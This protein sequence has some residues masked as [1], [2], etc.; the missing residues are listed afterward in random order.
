MKTISLVLVGC[1]SLKDWIKR[2]KRKQLVRREL[3]NLKLRLQFFN[4]NGKFSRSNWKA[5][6][7]SYN[8]TSAT[9]KVFSEAS[10]EEFISTTKQMQNKN[11]KIEKLSSYAKQFFKVFLKQKKEFQKPAGRAYFH[12]FSSLN[13]K[14]GPRL[15]DSLENVAHVLMLGIIDFR[16]IPNFTQVNKT[17]RQKPYLEDLMNALQRQSQLIINELSIWLWICGSKEAKIQASTFAHKS[18]F[19][20]VYK[21]NM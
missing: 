3:Q 12:L 19:T 8:I 18:M 1:Y 9:I 15:E 16:R 21:L 13:N 17:T 14:L 20:D 2:W 10:R 7:Q 6:K 5:F 11:R 4:Q